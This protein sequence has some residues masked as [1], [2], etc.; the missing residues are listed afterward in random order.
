M[1]NLTLGT[2]FKHIDGDIGNSEDITKSDLQGDRYL[3]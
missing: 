1:Y 3:Y 2:K